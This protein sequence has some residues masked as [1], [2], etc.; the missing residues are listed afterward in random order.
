MDQCQKMKHDSKR[1]AKFLA[2]WLEDTLG[3][4]ASINREHEKIDLVHPSTV[5]FGSLIGQNLDKDIALCQLSFQKHR[6]S[7]YC[8]RDRKQHQKHETVDERKR[9]WCR[10]GA[11]IERTYGKCDTPGFILR[12][13]PV[14][15]KDL[16]GFD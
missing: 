14:I 3:M 10:C 6:C 15:F 8:M 5:R 13:E 11:G 2:S 1:L 4:T 12:N 9:R 16:R 7:K